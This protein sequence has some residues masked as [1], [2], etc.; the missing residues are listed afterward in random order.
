ML[1][2]LQIIHDIDFLYK[3]VCGDFLEHVL[4]LL[5]SCPA[6]VLDLVKPSILQ[7]GNLLNDLVP[8]VINTIVEAL[9]KKSNEVS[10]D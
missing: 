8:L 9:V 3:R 4:K 2:P 7:G 6:D 10:S 5:S 1:L